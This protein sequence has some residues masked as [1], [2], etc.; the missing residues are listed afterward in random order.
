MIRQEEEEAEWEVNGN[1]QIHARRVVQVSVTTRTDGK[2]SYCYA[3]YTPT[4]S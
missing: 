1:E 4:E 3:P 2:L